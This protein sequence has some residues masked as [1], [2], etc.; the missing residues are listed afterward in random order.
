MLRFCPNL[1]YTVGA[2]E[3]YHYEDVAS[4]RHA[5]A[6]HRQFMQVTDI[7]LDLLKLVNYASL[8]GRVGWFLTE[9]IF[10]ALLFHWFYC[11]V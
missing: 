4:S 9:I 7:P 6:S 3:I 8:E 2:K 1:R 5:G 11:R 10:V